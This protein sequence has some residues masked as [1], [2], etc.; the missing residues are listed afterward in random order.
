MFKIF[1]GHFDV[2]YY[3]MTY[4]CYQMPCTFNTEGIFPQVA[5]LGNEYQIILANCKLLTNMKCMF[6][7]TE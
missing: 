6:D 2:T 7:P 5:F 4:T 3:N 1:E